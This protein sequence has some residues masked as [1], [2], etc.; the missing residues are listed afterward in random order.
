MR[1]RWSYWVDAVKLFPFSYSVLNYSDIFFCS[2]TRTSR[3]QETLT[4]SNT[5]FQMWFN[6]KYNIKKIKSLKTRK[7]MLRERKTVA[8]SERNAIA[9]WTVWYERKADKER[10][11]ASETKKIVHNAK[12][13]KSFFFLLCRSLAAC[14]IQF[15][16]RFL[17]LT[18]F[19][20]KSNLPR[21]FM[22][23]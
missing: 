10:Q 12:T 19:V 4:A 17:S 11:R 16:N 15:K 5:R 23:G 1:I 8:R 20:L 14:S 9:Y 6:T 2:Y 22:V 13:N 21:S 7:S 3:P 18:S